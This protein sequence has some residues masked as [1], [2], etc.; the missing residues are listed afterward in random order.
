VPVLDTSSPQLPRHLIQEILSGNC[1]AFVGAGFS[2]EAKFPD[3]Y[4][5]LDSIRE[6]GNIRED[7]SESLREVIDENR[8]ASKGG[9][10]K[11]NSGDL[12]RCAQIL[13]DE[14]GPERLAEIV[15]DVLRT[16][17]YLPEA[18]EERLRLLRGIPFRAILTTNFDLLIPGPP[19]AH[20]DAKPVMHNV[21]RGEPL[22]LSDYLRQSQWAPVLQLHGS[23]GQR[24]CKDPGLAFTR[25]GYRRLLHGDA[26]YTKFL[27]TVMATKTVLYLGFSFSDE[28]INELRSSTVMMLGECKQIAYAITVNKTPSEIDFFYKHEGVHMLNFMAPPWRGFDD[29]LLAIHDRTNPVLRWARSLINKKILWGCNDLKNLNRVIQDRVRELGGS[30][31]IDSWTEASYGSSIVEWAVNRMRNEAYDLFVTPYSS[32]T[33]ALSAMH[34]MVPPENY[35]PV[36]VYSVNHEDADARKKKC[37]QHGARQYIT[38]VET[39]LSEMFAVLGSAEE[40]K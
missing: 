10:D 14:M 30:V 2:I 34:R 12:D 36:I 28:Y 18:M 21:L 35:T 39:L 32:A 5:L 38:K 31:Q 20:D 24:Y 16:P 11:Q 4:D 27:S 6:R 9:G 26:S 17:E 33:Q 40:T 1:V 23:I 7:L 29:I 25:L 19:A 22:K 3:W 13:E 37:L 8:P 15:A